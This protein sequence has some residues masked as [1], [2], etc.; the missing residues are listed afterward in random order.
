MVKVALTVEGLDFWRFPW[1]SV[2][3]RQRL[4]NKSAATK[5]GGRSRRGLG[6]ELREL[7]ASRP[8]RL[9]ERRPCD[10]PCSALIDPGSVYRSTGLSICTLSDP[11]LGRPVAGALDA[12]HIPAYLA[13]CCG[14]KRRGGLATALPPLPI[15]SGLQQ[16]PLGRRSLRVLVIWLWRSASLRRSAW[17]SLGRSGRRG[18]VADWCFP[19]LRQVFHL[20]Y[21]PRSKGRTAVCALRSL[22]RMKKAR[23]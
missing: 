20:Q 3:S 21:L 16:Q 12:S 22:R 9:R 15:V 23:S 4:R 17:R 14:A 1:A 11:T 2:F 10:R 8:A 7:S 18:R 6:Y 19:L 5:R 13:R